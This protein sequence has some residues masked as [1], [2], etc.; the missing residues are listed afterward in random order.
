MERRYHETESS[1]VREDLARFLSS[2]PCP[3]CEGTRLNPAARSVYID[4][5]NLPGVSAMTITDAA[6]YFQ[7]LTL[8]G[9]RG[10]IAEKILKEISERLQL[11]GRRRPRT[12]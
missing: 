3:D 5:M 1:M 6:S 7:T 12:I 2:Q 8:Q 10:E 4:N 11:S 9:N